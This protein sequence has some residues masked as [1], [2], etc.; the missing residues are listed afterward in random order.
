MLSL[1]ITPFSY[2]LVSIYWLRKGLRL[3][4]KYEVDMVRFAICGWIGFTLVYISF[5]PLFDYLCACLRFSLALLLLTLP[6]AHTH[7]P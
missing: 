7:A 4:P 6:H 2:L 1:L 5:V 3:K